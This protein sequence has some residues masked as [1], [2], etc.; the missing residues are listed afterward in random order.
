MPSPKYV[1]RG[2]LKKF[3]TES[4]GISGTFSAFAFDWE[5]SAGVE[6]NTTA[7][8]HDNHR[9]IGC[10]LRFNLKMNYDAR[11][12][13]FTVA[14]STKLPLRFTSRPKG[15]FSVIA[16]DAAGNQSP[17]ETRLIVI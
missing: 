1:S 12:Y 2:S 17:A 3:G 10:L 16:R 8:E 9:L 14:S 15:T 11:I 6:S 5:K 7:N 4:Y 13:N